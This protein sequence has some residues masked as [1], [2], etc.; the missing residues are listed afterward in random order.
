[1][2]RILCA[3]PLL[4]L[5]APAARAGDPDF[6]AVVRAVESDLGIRRTHIP[7]FGTAMFFVRAARP[8]GVKQLDMAIFD[9]AGDSRPDFARF[10]KIMRRAVGERWT[11][12]IRVKDRRGDELT[13]IYVKA[14]GRDW[15]MILATFSPGE[16]VLIHLKLGP[17]ALR[18]ILDE[19]K[20]AGKSLTGN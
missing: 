15:T 9:E 3:A 6:K 10:E 12:M 16:A 14:A 18:D 7:L 20:H 5:L 13:Y 17:E 11:P 2:K 8:E 4:L 1:M 19:P